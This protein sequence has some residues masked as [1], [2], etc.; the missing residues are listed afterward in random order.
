MS[1]ST[2]QKKRRTVSAQ[3]ARARIISV[4]ARHF[5]RKGFKETR[6]EDI[7]KEIGQRHTAILYHF[8]TKRELYDA[9]L[10]SLYGEGLAILQEISARDCSI[11]ERLWGIINALVDRSVERPELAMLSIRGAI[12]SDENVRLTAH[13]LANPFSDLFHIFIMSLDHVETEKDALELKIR[14]VR[15]LFGQGIYFFTAMPNLLDVA[16]SKLFASEQIMVLKDDLYR[17]G[18]RI[19]DLDPDAITRHTNLPSTEQSF[20]EKDEALS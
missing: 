7:A 17:D 20:L 3:E 8:G 1:V 19:L 11:Q 16:P 2:I 12:D 14:L 6:V 4:S 5:G 18:C 9:V 10:N 15:S 13:E